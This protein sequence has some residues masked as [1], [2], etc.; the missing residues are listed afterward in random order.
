MSSLQLHTGLQVNRD[1]VVRRRD[2]LKGISLA[3]AAGASGTLG[4][5]NLVA[6]KADE[7]RSRGMACILLFM[8]GGPSQFETFSPKPGHEN[9]GETKAIDTSVAGIQIAHGLPHMARVM[10][11][12]AVLRAV[13]AKEGN[14]ARAEFLMHTGYAPTPTVKHP[15][16]GSIVAHQLGDVNFDLP[17]FVRIAGRTTDGGGLLG[18]EYDPFSMAN[19]E[20]PANAKLTTG[21]PRFERRMN[22]LS[23]L[24][25]SYARGGAE[26][27]VANHQKLYGKAA[28]MVTSARMEA[29]QLDR[30]PEAVRARYGKGDFASGC[31][32]ARRLIESGVTFVEV[33]SN[34][35][36]THDNVFERTT[37]LCGQVDQPMAALITDLKERGMLDKTLVIWMG[38]FGRTPKIN[39]RGGRDHFPRASNV[40]LAGGG[41]RGGQVI[42]HTDAGGDTVTDHP[43][44][45][46]DLFQ[47]FCKSLGINPAIENMS[48][49][50]RPIKIVDGGQPVSELF[51]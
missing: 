5:K 18:V 50:G 22:L 33:G 48:A 47:S 36:D 37:N 21:Q 40:A 20:A 38:E 25:S 35:W 46:Q 43:V 11:D 9:G 12:V 10:Q 16:L 2:F 41:V 42:G 27:E 4:W 32:L 15:T 17:S 39:P 23:Q 3:G 6:A 28:K 44:S 49:I 34:G 1:R 14:H 51:G 30:E 29:F 7:L 13:T 31:L 24:E 8:K 19:A 26:R 45:V